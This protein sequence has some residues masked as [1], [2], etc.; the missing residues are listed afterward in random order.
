[1][2]LG[3][4]RE[5]VATPPS[6]SQVL[7]RLSDLLANKQT[8]ACSTIISMKFTS[9]IAVRMS[10]CV[11]LG[12][13]HLGK[14]RITRSPYSNALCTEIRKQLLKL[15]ESFG[16]EIGSPLSESIT[17]QDLSHRCMSGLHSSKRL[18]YLGRDTTR[19]KSGRKPVP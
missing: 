6:D 11:T 15:Y 4:T 14:L 16:F 10:F 5:I 19:T 8:W 9:I 2:W 3:D 7:L 17:V 1:M 12:Q 13:F 18:R